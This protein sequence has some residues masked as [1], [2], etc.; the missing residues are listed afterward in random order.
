MH[1]SSTWITRS[2]ALLCTTLIALN[3]GC[4]PAPE[5]PRFSL[6]EGVAPD[7]TEARLLEEFYP[8]YSADAPTVTATREFALRA[9]PTEADIVDEKGLKVW[10]FNGVVPGPTFRV[11]IGEKV[12]ITLTNDLPQPTTIHWHGVRVPNAMDG[13]PGV[14]QPPVEPGEQFVYEFVPKDAGTFWFHPHVRGSEQIERGLYGVLVVEDLKPPPYS[15]DVVWVLDDWLL[16]EDG[17]IYP[18]FVTRHD[19]A[20]DGRWGNVATVNGST[21]EQLIVKPGE[22]I[23]LRMVDSANG[24]MFAPH[25]EGLEP[26]IIAVDGMYTR[27]PLPLEHFEIS[28][29]NRLDV[30]IT[31]PADSGGKTF[32]VVDRFTRNQFVLATIR[33]EDVDAVKSPQFEAPRNEHVP[34]WE[35]AHE[36]D[37]DHVYKLDARS[38][39]PHG[40]EWMINDKVWGEHEASA[41][42]P[43][44]WTKVRFQN[45]SYRLHP[46]H[47]HGQF[48]KVIARNDEPV[49]EPYFRDTVL[50]KRKESVDVGM[51]PLDWGNWLMHCHILEHA[52]SGMRTLLTVEGENEEKKESAD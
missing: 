38:G 19:L 44:R 9:A 4:T 47:I 1:R 31:I 20:H 35:G 43:D 5:K 40:I 8:A 36:L 34:Y 42:P 29:G 22:R 23:R 14:T 45:E 11:R 28:P 26:M 16:D 7:S 46:M 30:D 24:R 17:Q 10:A 32:T 33:V 51:V 13:V 48:F 21:A 41:L 12:K 2:R 25:F 49:D 52:E 18:H 50:L 39:G 15:Q 37:V 3:S 27:R 6:P